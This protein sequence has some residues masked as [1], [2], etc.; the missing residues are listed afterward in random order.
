[1]LEKLK[2]DLINR[3]YN[4]TI[5][6][7]AN[8][9]VVLGYLKANIKYFQAKSKKAKTILNE[10][11]SQGFKTEAIQDYDGFYDIHVYYK[12]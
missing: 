1:M 9:V 6:A 4:V 11:T 3:G 5:P 8:Y 2:A 10:L 7:N 12:N